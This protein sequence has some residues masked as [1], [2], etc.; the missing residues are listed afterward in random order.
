MKYA[1]AVSHDKTQSNELSFVREKTLEDCIWSKKRV[2]RGHKSGR[3]CNKSMKT[4][5]E[6][7]M[8]NG[9]PKHCKSVIFSNDK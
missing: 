4:P 2:R 6:K 9:S 7:S 5:T 1:E 3:Y 8:P